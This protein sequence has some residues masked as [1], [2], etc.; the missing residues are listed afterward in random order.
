M[1]I[2]RL[3]ASRVKKFE[4]CPKQYYLRYVEDYEIPDIEDNEY[5]QLGNAI[6]DSIEHVLTN[7]P[8][9]RDEDRLKELITEKNEEIKEYPSGMQSDAEECIDTAASFIASNISSDGI[10]DVEEFWTMERDGVEFRGLLD[11]AGDGVIYDWKTGKSEGKE[12][13]EKI[14]AAVYIEMYYDEYGEY[15]ETVHFVYLKEGVLSTHER[16]DDGEVYWNSVENKYFETV[17]ENVREIRKSF[18]NGEWE[19][20][21]GSSKC[22]FCDYKLHCKDSKVGSEDVKRHHIEIGI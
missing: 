3:S 7:H 22:H 15:P 1:T 18:R 6:H 9:L 4:S 10:R 5:I 20:D 12:L 19:A 14:Q 17:E 21:P 8:N 2:E 13:D 11:V 16:V